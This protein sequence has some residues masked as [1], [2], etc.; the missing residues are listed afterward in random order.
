MVPRPLFAVLMVCDTRLSQFDKTAARCKKTIRFFV[1]FA[2][3]MHTMFLQLLPICVLV[4]LSM[5][6]CFARPAEPPSSAASAAP[7]AVVSVQ[8]SV[9][10]ERPLHEVFAFV[11]NAENDTTW[12]SEVRS[13]KNVTLQVLKQALESAPAA[14]RATP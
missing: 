9:L 3:A 10:I 5:S 14:Q 13:L 4:T 8:A 2:F 7:R 6:R 12:R 11:A 1:T